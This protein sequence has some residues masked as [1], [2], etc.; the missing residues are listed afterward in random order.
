MDPRAF[1]SLLSS[2]SGL[3]ANKDLSNYG[4][5]TD[6]KCRVN[7]LINFRE[8]GHLWRVSQLEFTVAAMAL[9]GVLLFSTL[10]GAV[11][12]AVA[13]GPASH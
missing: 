2:S 13:S 11:A 8:I 1:P 12:A 3:Y 10:K 5:A 6:G 4:K 7:G 9:V